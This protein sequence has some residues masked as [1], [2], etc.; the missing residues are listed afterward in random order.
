MSPP[1]RNNMGAGAIFCDVPVSTHNFQKLEYNGAPTY[2]K[3]GSGMTAK[4]IYTKLNRLRQQSQRAGRVKLSTSALLLGAEAGIHFL[5]AAVLAGAP[6][7][8]SK[9]P[10]VKGGWQRRS[11]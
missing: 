11:R 10:L 1:G 9:G 6:R 3:E 5:L 8:R 2:T 4:T 7:S